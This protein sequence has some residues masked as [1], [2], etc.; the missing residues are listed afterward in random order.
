MRYFDYLGEKE[1]KKLFHKFPKEFN[2]NELWLNSHAY[3][4]ERK[5][6]IGRLEE[7]CPW[8]DLRDVF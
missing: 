4:D 5:R 2:K 7:V 1:E 8:D 3:A 6:C